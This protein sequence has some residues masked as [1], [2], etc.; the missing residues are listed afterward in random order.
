MP[1]V[2][3]ADDIL[4][5][6]KVL[7]EI[8]EK[9]G[10]TVVAEAGDGVKAIEKYQKKKPDIVLLDILMPNMDGIAA[11]REIMKINKNAKIVIVSALGQQSRIAEAKKIG[12]NNYLIKPFKS[13]VVIKNVKK[14]LA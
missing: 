14:A 11:A 12:V 3:I 10:F 4:F 9:E 13:D 8:L 2:L 1:T 5:I 6:R 7:R